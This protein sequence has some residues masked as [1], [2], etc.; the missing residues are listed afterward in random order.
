MKNK[1][2]KLVV[3]NAKESLERPGTRLHLSCN[4][5]RDH[6]LFF[7]EFV[8]VFFRI[9]PVRAVRGSDLFKG[10]IFIRSTCSR[11]HFACNT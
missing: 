9:S 10:A 1:S 8:L 3:R 6:F 11:K 5:F 4:V 7:L 2:A